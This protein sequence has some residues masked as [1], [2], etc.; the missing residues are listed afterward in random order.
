MKN[1]SRKD[2]LSFFRRLLLCAWLATLFGL[3]H[4]SPGLEAA[5]VFDLPEPGQRVGLS[6]VYHPATLSGIKVSKENPLHFEFVVD[7]GSTDLQGEALR[8]EINKLIKYFLAALTVPENDLWVNLSPYE[9]ERIIPEAFGRTDMGK[10]L[11]AQDYLLKQISSSLTYPEDE[12]GKR[13]WTQVP[14]MDQEVKSLSKVWIMP[15]RAVVYEKANVAYVSDSKLKVMLESDYAALKNSP[16]AQGGSAN[17]RNDEKIEQAMRELILPRLENEVNNGENFAQLRQVYH[18]IILAAWYKRRIRSFLAAVYV[19]KNKVPGIT[20][21]DEQAAEQIWDQ[22]VTAFQKGVF[23]LI[24]EE[25]AADTEELIPRKYFCGGFTSTKF[26]LDQ[27]LTFSSS[28]SSPTSNR[29]VIVES[30][31]DLSDR[32]I[33]TRASTPTLEEMAASFA[34]IYPEFDR[35]KLEALYAE[36]LEKSRESRRMLVDDQGRFYIA[37]YDGWER[38]EDEPLEPYTQRVNDHPYLTFIQDKYGITDGYIEEDRYEVSYTDRHFWVKGG[39]DYLI[40]PDEYRPF[41]EMLL[42]MG[43]WAVSQVLNPDR[44][45]PSQGPITRQLLKDKRFLEIHQFIREHH[46]EFSPGRLLQIY[47]SR[48]QIPAVTTEPLE[49]K[50]I[51]GL[52]PQYE[53]PAGHKIILLNSRE[54]VRLSYDDVAEYRARYGGQTVHEKKTQDPL[55]QALEQKFGITGA[56][57]EYRMFFEE[58]LDSGSLHNGFSWE[59]TE[60]I[61][62]E[63]AADFVAFYLSVS[64]EELSQILNP[65]ADAASVETLTAARL[66]NLLK[67]KGVADPQV[68]NHFLNIAR[69]ALA[70]NANARIQDLYKL[71]HPMDAPTSYHSWKNIFTIAG[72]ANGFLVENRSV[73]KIEANDELEPEF[74]QRVESSYELDILKNDFGIPA[75]IVRKEENYQQQTAIDHWGQRWLSVGL[76]VPPESADLVALTL[77]VGVKKVR[78]IIFADEPQTESELAD[79]LKAAGVVD[80]S[81]DDRLLRTFRHA[82]WVNRRVDLKAL[83]EAYDAVRNHF[84]APAS[85]FGD[86]QRFKLDDV[87]SRVYEHADLAGQAAFYLEYH[88]GYIRDSPFLSFL[89]QKLRLNRVYIEGIHYTP[90]NYTSHQDMYSYESFLYV[91]KDDKDFVEFY[92]LAGASKINKILFPSTVAAEH[93]V[94]LGTRRLGQDQYTQRPGN[95]EAGFRVFQKLGLN[96]PPGIALS[97]ELVQQILERPEKET[98]DFVKAI[99]EEMK[100]AGIY[101]NALFSVRSNPKRSMPGILNTITKTYQVLPGIREVALSWYTEQAKSFRQR[102]KMSDEYD[103]PIIVQLWVDGEKKVYNETYRVWDKDYDYAKKRTLDAT[104]PFYGAGVFSTRNPDTAA[105]GLFG[106]YVENQ[107]GAEIMTAGNRGRDIGDLAQ[108]AP[109][110]Y[111]ELEEA[112]RKLEAE[113]GPQE[114]EFVVNNG[115]IYFLQTRRIAFSP[116]A[117]FNYL[118]GQLAEGKISEAKAIPVIERLQQKLSSRKSYRI[119]DGVEI[120]PLARAQAGTPGA[121]YGRLVWDMDLAVRLRARNEPVIF[122]ADSENQKRILPIV[123][124]YPEVG[125]ITRY[126]NNSSH[127]AVLTRLAG[128][129]SL[130]NLEFQR[131]G[132]T[133]RLEDGTVLK[134]G[135]AVVID[136]DRQMLLTLDRASL[137]E[138]E[139]LTDASYGIQIPQMRQE[140]LAPY[141][142]ADGTIKPEF[143]LE[144]LS[145]LNEAAAQKFERLNQGTDKRAAFI[146]NLEKHFLHD[147]LTEQQAKTP[148]TA[149]SAANGDFTRGGIDLR[150]PGL[151]LETRGQFDQD[152]LVPPDLQGLGEEQIPG[153]RPVILNITPTVNL[154]Q[155]LGLSDSSQPK[156]NSVSIR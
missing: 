27:V 28:A 149:S 90:Q 152:F 126:G 60:L 124:D 63:A 67:Q 57:I 116:Q 40:V 146:A 29:Q 142:N 3:G 122:V 18:S 95:K 10:D 31:L 25:S 84:D 64:A 35:K 104:L 85:D 68:D 130:I 78:D 86:F 46:P 109:E 121:L 61:L 26:D 30:E 16:L 117:E 141:L 48:D 99:R 83:Y 76:F 119:K 4:L 38:Y 11:L 14:G 145:Q 106:R 92:L 36:F 80:P 113:V 81:V 9:K 87:G 89:R 98:G 22:Y 136:G 47:L 118:Q 108:S 15:A 120:K 2:R 50:A 1:G 94:Q 72:E 56:Y 49:F 147:L 135:N 20:I 17:P 133:I 33:T 112:G 102:E 96:Y 153:F 137:V 125:L 107:E 34:K 101:E 42:Q 129:P 100:A 114:V 127:E 105:D 45:L 154:P 128:I 115:R 65:P 131:S 69:Q 132:N 139:G 12:L 150:L 79:R 148:G 103:L 134:E 43:E 54:K 52:L 62:P 140:F 71:Y 53:V 5:T 6:R 138:S 82:L 59:V 75:Y 91:L 41:I 13:F 51:S 143:T 73:G 74:E 58:D 123:F 21:K 23:N 8:T 24:K 155:F 110:V 7:L 156:L 151:N 39:K 66:Q 97:E 88:G 44:F 93:A 37:D 19:D 77:K 144:V 111:R 32:E 70:I 55:L